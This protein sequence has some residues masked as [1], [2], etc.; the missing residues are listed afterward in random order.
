MFL[1]V[2]ADSAMVSVDLEA[3]IDVGNDP[4]EPPLEFYVSP[5]KTPIFEEFGQNGRHHAHQREK[6]I[7]MVK[8]Q[9]KR[10]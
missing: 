6:M 5:T 9:L 8:F 1:Y 7:Q 4:P 2:F 3:S 10:S